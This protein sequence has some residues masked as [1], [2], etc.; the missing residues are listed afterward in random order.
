[1][2]ETPAAESANTETGP[3]G[4]QS[5]TL[6]QSADSEPAAPVEK[7]K[8][9]PRRRATK[10]AA[11]ETEIP[12]PTADPPRA[13]R[14]SRS[15]KE[16]LV[17]ADVEPSAEPAA[18]EA[19]TAPRRRRRTSKA[20]D[21]S[22]E[23]IVEAVPTAT[24]LTIPG[25]EETPEESTPEPPAADTPREGG[26]SNRRRSRRGR[27]GSN[28][29]A[30][31]PS[32]AVA[33]LD[34]E[35]LTADIAITQDGAAVEPIAPEQ[36]E[37]RKGGRRSRRQ[38]RTPASLT[39]EEAIKLAGLTDF[40]TPVTSTDS[41]TEQPSKKGRSRRK[42]NTPETVL[43][44]P[45]VVEAAAET[46]ESA[47]EA[48]RRSRRRRGRRRRGESDEPIEIAESAELLV[49]G[50]AIRALE[51]E[52]ED[53]DEEDLDLVPLT[54]PVQPVYVAPPLVP[55][56]YLTG[57]VDRSVRVDARIETVG[58]SGHRRFNINGEPHNPFLFFVNT[59][60]ATD[61]N[62]VEAQIRGAAA[63]GIHLY[64]AVMYLPLKNAYGERPFGRIDSVLGQILAA[65][66]EA[67]IIPRLQ[68][69]PTNYW[70]R[71][72]PDQ[73]ARY[74]DGSEGDVSIA[75]QTF[76]ADCLE[77][78]T[79][80]IEH[81]ADPSTPG[82]DHIIG[83]HIDRGEWFHDAA[84]GYDYSEPNTTGFRNWLR[85]K[86]QFD[87][88]L[89][90]AWYDGKVT[91]D[92]S[93]I[94]P[95]QGLA[96]VTKKSDSPLLNGPRDGRWVDY[97]KY[98]SEVVAEAITGIAA[99]I[100]A[101]TARKLLVAVSYGYSLEFSVRNDSGHLSLSRLLDS[102][103]IDII[104]GPN[105]YT[106]RG[107]GNTGAFGAPLDSVALHGKLWVMEDDTKTFLADTETEDTYNP[108]I[109]TGLETQATHERH[110][111]AA[112]T[113][114]TGL[115]WMDLWGQGWLND[116]M[117]WQ[118]LGELS[119]MAQRWSETCALRYVAPDTPDY[120]TRP[121]GR[122]DTI[123]ELGLDPESEPVSDAPAD[124]EEG[125]AF[126]QPLDGDAAPSAFDGETEP[127]AYDGE[128]AP[129]DFENLDE[130]ALP[131]DAGD[132]S[133]AEEAAQVEIS[134]QISTEEVA[135]ETTADSTEPT[136]DSHVSQ[137]DVDPVSE[138]DTV[139]QPDDSV[140]YEPTVSD[141]TQPE[142]PGEASDEV[143]ADAAAEPENDPTPGENNVPA[144]TV[145]DQDSVPDE[146][147]PETL[148]E[149]SS[150][151][152]GDGIVEEPASETEPE[153]A[154][155]A[156]PN[157]NAISADEPAVSANEQSDNAEPESAEIVEPD[158]E[159]APDETPVD[160]ESVNAVEED[161]SEVEVPSD[162]R[163]ESTSIESLIDW[164]ADPI[165]ETAMIEADETEDITE[166]DSAEPVE[167]SIVAA[168]LEEAIA[169]TT[170]LIE[171]GILLPE[172]LD[173][174]EVTFGE[175]SL[176]AP[177]GGI[178]ID[179]DAADE[180]QVIQPQGWFGAAP[181]VVAFIDEASLYYMKN[182]PAGLGH[183][184]ISRTREM[185]LKTG[186]SVSFFLQSDVVRPDLPDAPLYL[187]LNALRITTAERQA[188]R[189]R[190][191]QRGKTLAWIYA[192]GILDET[193][194]SKQDAGDVIGITLR[195]Q[196]WNT[197]TGSQV[198]EQRHPITERMRSGKRI[199]QDEI[200]NPSFAVDDPQATALAEYVSNGATSI[201]V[202]EH[203]A[204]WRSVFF[205]EPALTV[206]LL[207][208]LFQ[209]AGVPLYSAQDD[210]VHAT[211]DG[212]ILLHAGYTGQRV[213][214][215]PFAAT[216]YD[217]GENRIIAV[218]SRSFRTFLRSRTSRLFLFGSSD[219]IADF[220]G[221][222]I[223][224]EPTRGSRPE[225]QSRVAPVVRD[226][227]PVAPVIAEPQPE[228][229]A[230][231]S[232]SRAIPGLEFADELDDEDDETEIPPP[233]D[234]DAPAAPRSRWQR[235][236]AAARARREAERKAKGSVQG[237]QPPVDLTTL[238][239]DLPPRRKPAAP[240]EPGNSAD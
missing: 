223:P 45:E 195:H 98:S 21:A 216:V 58:A 233:S 205:G 23:A 188:I 99:A 211:A 212:V 144:E 224:V 204:G 142:I 181:D 171:A 189:E 226:P 11:D 47:D 76:W 163:A 168:A 55:Q 26:Q 178:F 83:F 100:K 166:D 196:P 66:P 101:L 128:T 164:A 79:A 6:E 158:A 1:M 97:A 239:P 73:L 159:G 82:G 41:T 217:T 148:T 34:L 154:E 93:A 194:P 230:K 132:A 169:E 52:L 229:V 67:Y 14:A 129:A 115:A 108:K 94:P 40:V 87:Y 199:G 4:D 149:E 215:L 49:D 190:L 137:T 70:V 57:S 81:F 64:S 140:A 38:D 102:A 88:A 124:D 59:E 15:K 227:E 213:I 165:E 187:F 220:T 75:S 123:L 33:A 125:V 25:L 13:P 200:L 222:E 150:P 54:P 218:E 177:A 172:D 197:R 237:D 206:E 43:A 126:E 16:P 10:A 51:L 12:A 228:P 152:D 71:T 48:S 113:H 209:Y 121:R 155:E 63:N 219:E 20:A 36:P 69:V 56:S 130:T 112:L 80:L 235:R 3:S 183:S 119:N 35:A 72:N 105:S 2:S 37:P 174:D 110:F 203:S 39:T 89:R 193:G 60:T 50:D 7:P 46:A 22:A 151:T 19:T 136:V 146:V 202:R 78:V 208:G 138:N 141:E 92:T 170:A 234:E 117:I 90:A 176:D 134:E 182:D 173:F 131:S 180:P 185:L 156:L 18:P 17:V 162:I 29:A 77:A 207:R 31:N 85:S 184:L 201:A 62:V 27:G 8:R 53:E 42:R 231:Q 104:A 139:P 145:L 106:S 240:A 122:H 157:A 114:R 68:L 91:F 238:M 103:D 192:P 153:S 143:Q 198:V 84:A 28:N 167:T 210:V 225:P 236:R 5:P 109:P 116:P 127:A 135:D 65:D 161:A 44:Q 186:A 221:L 179:E 61:G 95:W 111:G 147:T 175:V 107:A 160:N 214:N 232:I 96:A 133:P 191:Q 30:K 120:Q 24:E 9:A 32:E 86:Y 118:T 74:A